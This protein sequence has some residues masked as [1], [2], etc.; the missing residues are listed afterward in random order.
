MKPGIKLWSLAGLCALAVWAAPV[1]AQLSDAMA[2]QLS[3]NADQHV[4]VIMKNQFATAPAG[5]STV[6]RSSAVAADQAPLMGEL[7]QVHARNVKSYR[8]VNAF[9][10]TVSKGYV[11]RLKSHP[12]VARVLPD[13]TIRVRGCRLRLIRL[14]RA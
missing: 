6:E 13:V 4:I 5:S 10:A 12:L 8:L 2:G 1:S 3:Q 14:P 11:E 7:G 9:A